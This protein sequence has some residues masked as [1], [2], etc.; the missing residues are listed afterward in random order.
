MELELALFSGFHFHFRTGWLFHNFFSCHH[1]YTN[2]QLGAPFFPSSFHSKYQHCKKVGLA[3]VGGTAAP[4]T[5]LT[6][7][8]RFTN[9]KVNLKYIGL[10]IGAKMQFVMNLNTLSVHHDFLESE[11]LQGT[12]LVQN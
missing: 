9:L 8:K 1:S 7:T 10:Y 4:H 11:G 6:S 5:R 12:Y 2:Y 3:C